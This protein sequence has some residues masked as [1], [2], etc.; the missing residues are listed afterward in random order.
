[1]CYF[2]RNK[3]VP[4]Q[5]WGP[6]V[7]STNWRSW[8]SNTL[9]IFRRIA[10]KTCKLSHYSR[11]LQHLYAHMV[12]ESLKLHLNIESQN[13]SG[14]K[15]PSRSSSPTTTQPS[16][17]NK[18]PLNHVLEHHIQTVFKHIQGWWLNP[19]PGEPIPVLNHPFCKE[20]F[21][22]IQPKPPLV[23]LEAISPRPVTCHQWEETN[24]ALA[25]STFQILEESSKVSSQPPLPQ[26]KQPQ[27]P[28]S[29]L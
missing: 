9:F 18:P 14:W 21:L 26:I 13:R 11:V 28:Q 16:Y 7:P 23:Q 3:Q 2:Q 5:T 24:S 15:R 22:D 4:Q 10:N 1:M 20:V 12:Y 8:A 29:L 6:E 19:L 27:F 17:P 25:V